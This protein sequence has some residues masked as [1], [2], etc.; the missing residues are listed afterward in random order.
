MIESSACDFKNPYV[1]PQNYEIDDTHIG[2]RLTD[3]H[4][5]EN[6]EK[7]ERESRGREI[8]ASLLQDER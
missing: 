3:A 4:N 2:S 1:R 6:K 8:F 5:G 7:R